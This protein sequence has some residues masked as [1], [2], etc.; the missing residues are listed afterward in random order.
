M[1]EQQNTQT[2]QKLPAGIMLDMEH[3]DGGK[4]AKPSFTRE[5]AERIGQLLRGNTKYVVKIERI[6]SDDYGPR[7]YS[8]SLNETNRGAGNFNYFKIPLESGI[9]L[10]R[11]NQL[12]AQAKK[13]FTGRNKGSFRRQAVEREEN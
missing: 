9:D 3:W 12:I 7:G 4:Y 10:K 2:T 5:E 11:A 1:S 6:G 13:E 8:V